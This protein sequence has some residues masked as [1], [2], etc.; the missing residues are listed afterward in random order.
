MCD[1]FESGTTIIQPI[2]G[3][4]RLPVSNPCPSGRDSIQS[5]SYVNV[6]RSAVSWTIVLT[7]FDDHRQVITSSAASDE[8]T[9][10]SVLDKSTSTDYRMFTSL[11]D[12]NAKR[13][14]HHPHRGLLY[15][16]LKTNDK[17]S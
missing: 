17:G 12:R 16:D 15:L 4:S 2:M 10:D 8:R 13:E 11:Y 9:Q 6:T 7:S 14:E 5:S 3:R 1:N